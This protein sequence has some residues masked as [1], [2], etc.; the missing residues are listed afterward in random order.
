MVSMFHH[1]S[2]YYKAENELCFSKRKDL[3][4]LSCSFWNYLSV[5]VPVQSFHSHKGSTG[6]FLYQHFT[7]L[8]KTPCAV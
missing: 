3:S 5:D 2:M 8:F 7:Y 4:G 6:I 1:V